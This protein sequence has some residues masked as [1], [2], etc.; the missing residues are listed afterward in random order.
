MAVISRTSIKQL[1]E[2]GDIIISPYNES[3][4][5]N[6]SVDVSLGKWY[7]LQKGGTRSSLPPAPID[8]SEETIWDS[9]PQQIKD[10][11]IIWP[12]EM[13]LITTEQFIGSRKEC[14]TMAKTKSSLARFGLDL[15]GSSGW[16]DIGYINRWAFPLHNRSKFILKLKLGTWIGQIVFLSV[17][18]VEKS[19]TQG[20]S[21]QS[22]DDIDKLIKDW[23]PRSVLPKKL[24][25]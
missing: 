21:Y 17:S 13:I 24:S 4:I 22:T 25:T 11:L 5:G 8:T 2:K 14:T 6:C 16:G 18:D 15:C 10:Y 9:E 1:V 12:G 7:F 20:G 19:Y 3:K 23:D